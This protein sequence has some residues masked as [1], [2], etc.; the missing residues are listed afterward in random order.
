MLSQQSEHDIKFKSAQLFMFIEF[1]PSGTLS[2]PRQHVS[3]IWSKTELWRKVFDVW[4]AAHGQLFYLKHKPQEL[5]WSDTGQGS[6]HI[7]R[8][9]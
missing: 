2:M 5:P 4:D 7:K 3:E 9:L 6:M 8:F 1:A